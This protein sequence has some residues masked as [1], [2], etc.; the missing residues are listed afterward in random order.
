[1]ELAAAPSL[2]QLPLRGVEILTLL[3]F[4]HAEIFTC[5]KRK[6]PAPPPLDSEGGRSFLSA[7]IA[8][9]TRLE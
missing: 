6:P 3:A 7:A 5:L 1:V 9:A 4:M 2:A 8:G